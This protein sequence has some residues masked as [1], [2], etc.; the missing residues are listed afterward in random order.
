MKLAITIVEADLDDP[1]H[2]QAVCILLDAYA[3]D[4]MGRGEPL[5]Q[6]VKHDLVDGL[7]THPTTL[8][9]LA[10]AATRPVGVAVCFR[11]FSTFAARPLLNIHDLAV[12]PEFRGQGIGRRLLEET[13]RRAAE[14]GCCKVT[15]EVRDDNHLA[16][17]LYR[18][19]GY[20]TADDDCQSPRMLFW[21]CNIQPR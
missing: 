4:P 7:K 20:G 3:A 11:G 16:Q 15:L 8:V 9:L 6:S 21:T 12:L 13:H 19:M 18:S 10:F 5:G 17:R 1:C 2:Q 14:L